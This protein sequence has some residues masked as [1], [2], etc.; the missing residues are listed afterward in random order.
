VHAILDEGV[1][2]HVACATPERVFCTPM[3][4]GRQGESVLLHG[5]A[6]NQTLRAL[7][8]GARACVN[9]SLL[10]G[11]VL[12]RSAFR[13]SVDYRSVTLFG[14]AQALEDPAE[15]TEALR[16]IVEAVIP[17]RWRDVRAPSEKELAMTLVVRIPLEEVS[18]KVRAGGP[19][20]L[21][22]DLALPCWAG[23]IPVERVWGAPWGAADL[24]E[25]RPAPA[26]ATGYRRPV[27]SPDEEGNP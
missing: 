5:S 4:Y 9:V 27:A 22:E 1:Y 20:D 10:D 21:P 19:N 26:Y 14:V 16:V 11:L 25:G 15:K 17:E 13:T 24:P 23:V 2:C 18:A 6:S 8:G 7:A 12:G 3:V